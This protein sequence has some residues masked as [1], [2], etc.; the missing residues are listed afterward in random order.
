MR[1]FNKRIYL[2][3]VI[4]EKNRDIVD[5]GKLITHSR[6]D[7]LNP[8]AKVEHFSKGFFDLFTQ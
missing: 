2:L 1:E 7:S 6:G 4:E 8:Y 3:N 5:F